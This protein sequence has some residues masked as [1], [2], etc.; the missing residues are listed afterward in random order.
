VASDSDDVGV[1]TLA[2]V[3]K[4]FFVSSDSWQR[5][6]KSSPEVVLPAQS[7]LFDVVGGAPT[8][9]PRFS[10]QLRAVPAS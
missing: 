1:V 6:G 8:G 5:H 7:T 3:S 4:R 2:P 10:Q 9:F